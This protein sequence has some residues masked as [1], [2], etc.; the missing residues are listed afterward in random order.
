M[1]VCVCVGCYCDKKMEFGGWKNWSMLLMSVMS[2]YELDPE[3]FFPVKLVYKAAAQILPRLGFQFAFVGD[4]VIGAYYWYN[5]KPSPTTTTISTT[6]FSYTNIKH[7]IS[8]K[9]TSEICVRLQTELNWISKS[10]KWKL[11]HGP[12]IHEYGKST[13]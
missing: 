1:Y 5:E 11:K 9:S 13:R 7:R 3:C 6:Q 2:D 4:C 8:H 12:N 10:L